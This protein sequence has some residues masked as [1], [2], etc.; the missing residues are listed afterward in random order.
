VKDNP[1]EVGFD[2]FVDEARKRD[3]WDEFKVYY[4]GQHQKDPESWPLNL[5]PTEWWWTFGEFLAGAG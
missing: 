3:R 2:S 1:E 5:T 4:Q